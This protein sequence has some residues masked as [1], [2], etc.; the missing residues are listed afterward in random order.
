MPS[1]KSEQRLE[2][3]HRRLPRIVTK[4]EFIQVNL[5]L[6]TADTVMSPEQT[7]L[8]IANGPVCQRHRLAVVRV[9]D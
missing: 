6:I 9:S 8:E 1:S 5:E 2:R 4:Y 7:L 3:Y